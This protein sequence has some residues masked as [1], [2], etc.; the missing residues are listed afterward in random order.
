[1]KKLNI[2]A[3]LNK[4]EELGIHQAGLAKEM[5]VSRESISQWLKNVKMPRPAYLLK[6]ATVLEMSFSE[7]VIKEDPIGTYA[8]RTHRKAKLNEPRTE[9]AEVMMDLLDA[10]FKE[11]EPASLLAIPKLESPSL[12]YDYIQKAARTIRN[13]MNLKETQAVT[14]KHSIALMHTFQIILIPVLWTE[15]GD[16][17]LT[18]HLRKPNQFCLY[19]NIETKVCD[20]TFWLIHELAHILTPD[21]P[22]KE[23]EQFADS[24][25][26][27]LLFPQENAKKLGKELSLV[28]NTGSQIIRIQ[29]EATTRSVAPTYIFKEINC[30]LERNDKPL[31]D[32]NIFPASTNYRKSVPL[33]SDLLFE[34]KTPSAMQ[35]I[36]KSSVFFGSAFW[37]TLTRWLIAQEKTSSTVQAVLNIPLI[38]A[39]EVYSYLTKKEI[40]D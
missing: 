10:I 25:A 27:A 40:S 17:A 9:K 18:I 23:A 6:L 1:M 35:Y 34:E 22:Q 31:L 29:K 12:N 26:G 13:L 5:G 38:D 30:Y 8:Y 19:L 32:I 14:L 28:S 24:F 11:K 7:I 37:D 39:K 33:L 2:K 36:E 21:L 15:K 3:I 4:M 16:Q 20:L